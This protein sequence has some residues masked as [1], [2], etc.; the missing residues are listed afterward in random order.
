MIS[1]TMWDT[2]FAL[3]YDKNKNNKGMIVN[4]WR[5]TQNGL[6]IETAQTDRIHNPAATHACGCFVMV[7]LFLVSIPD[8]SAVLRRVVLCTLNRQVI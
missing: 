4:S 1:F 5:Q 7:P 2:S 6:T 8:R 3:K